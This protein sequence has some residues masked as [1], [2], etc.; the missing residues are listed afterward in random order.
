MKR[1]VARVWR[2]PVGYDELGG[3][4]HMHAH[5]LDTD[6]EVRAR[7]HGMIELC[8]HG[9]G[10]GQFVTYSYAQLTRAADGGEGALTLALVQFGRQ[11][12]ACRAAIGCDPAR[13][14]TSRRDL[15]GRRVPVDPRPEPPPRRRTLASRIVSAVYAALAQFRAPD[16]EDRP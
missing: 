15:R 10:H 11:H 3:F 7:G 1:Q 4:S 9:C 6:E 13:M 5:Y 16:E 8:C 12:A 2:S 14:S